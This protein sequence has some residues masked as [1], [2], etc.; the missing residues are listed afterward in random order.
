MKNGIKGNM[1][2]IKVYLNTQNPQN[3]KVVFK[4]G[5]KEE[6][7]AGIQKVMVGLEVDL[8]SIVCRLESVCVPFERKS[9][10]VVTDDYYFSSFRIIVD[11]DP[12]NYRDCHLKF[13]S[14]DRQRHTIAGVQK[15]NWSYS[16][17]NMLPNTIIDLLD[18]EVVKMRN[19][20][21]QK[22]NAKY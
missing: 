5:K 22:K 12:M 7:I 8:N 14:K 11:K 10:P 17:K 2:G 19:P 18:V 9:D 13:V 6:T 20:R 3:S 21:K 16:V 15:I 4:N 1:Y